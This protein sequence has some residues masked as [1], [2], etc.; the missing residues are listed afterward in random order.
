MKQSEMLVP[1]PWGGTC[2]DGDMGRFLVCRWTD[3]AVSDL[4]EI[5]GGSGSIYRWIKTGHKFT[6]VAVTRPQNFPVTIQG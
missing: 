4:P 1:M 5:I 3:R 2:G 6:T